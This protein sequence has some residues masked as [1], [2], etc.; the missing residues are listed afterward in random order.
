MLVKDVKSLPKWPVAILLEA[1]VS[2]PSGRCNIAIVSRGF[3]MPSINMALRP[4]L[5]QTH[6]TVRAFLTELPCREGEHTVLHTEAALALRHGP[7]SSL[8]NSRTRAQV[9]PGKLPLLSSH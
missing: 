7:L 4:L 8:L 9:H 5:H 6:S 1:L 3:W 2:S